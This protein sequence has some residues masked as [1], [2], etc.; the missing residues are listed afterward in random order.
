DRAPSLSLPRG[1][2]PMLPEKLSNGL[3]SL[4]PEVDRLCMVCDMLVTAAGEVHAYQFYPAVMFSHARMP[5]TEVAAILANT[6]GPEATRRKDL[7]PHFLNLHDVY[8]ALLKA[9]NARGAVDL[10]R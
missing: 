3:C 2:I 5:Y 4:N 6:R 7:V 1:V 8:R 9:R 10:D